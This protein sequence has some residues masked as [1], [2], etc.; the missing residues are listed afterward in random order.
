MEPAMLGY[1]SRLLL[2][3]LQQPKKATCQN[4]GIENVFIFNWY[5]YFILLERK[6]NTVEGGKNFMMNNSKSGSDIFPMFQFSKP[7]I[8]KKTQQLVVECVKCLP[9]QDKLSKKEKFQFSL[10]LF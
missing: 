2:G 7:G 4:L 6:P 10:Q 9:L 8:P 1:F 5:V 3:W